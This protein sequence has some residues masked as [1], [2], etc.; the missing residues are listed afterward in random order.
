MEIA[1]LAVVA[2]TVALFAARVIKD[3]VKILY[4]I[5]PL[6]VLWLA[7]FLLFDHAGIFDQESDV[8]DANYIESIKNS[9]GSG[10]HPENWHDVEV[11]SPPTPWGQSSED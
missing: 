7:M 10:G 3:A 9:G 2:L 8:Q 4:D 11:F 1:I 6:F 5:A